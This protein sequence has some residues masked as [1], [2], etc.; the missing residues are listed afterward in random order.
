ML[1]NKLVKV[2]SIKMVIKGRF[3]GKSRA[4]KKILTINKHM[5]LM[6]IKSRVDSAQSTVYGSNGTFGV[7]LWV[8]EKKN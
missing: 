4:S 8:N 3:N 6:T 5:P 7:K 2:T 1:T